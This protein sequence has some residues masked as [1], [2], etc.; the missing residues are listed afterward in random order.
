[1]LAAEVATRVKA[2]SGGSTPRRI[3]GA[4]A[5]VSAVGDG[6]LRY[7]SPGCAARTVLQRAK[8]VAETTGAAVGGVSRRT[9]RTPATRALIE[10]GWTPGQGGE[11][12]RQVIRTA[13]HVTIIEAHSYHR[14]VSD[15]RPAGN[16]IVKRAYDA[17]CPRCRKK[18]AAARRPP[19]G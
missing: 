7:D 10:S 14:Y 16:A 17:R 9:G 2:L 4:I 1:V 11:R 8:P 13:K 15:H 18:Q 3:L 12:E 19:D 6:G 5:T